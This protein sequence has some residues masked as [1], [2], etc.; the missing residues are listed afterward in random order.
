M[1]LESAPVR[2]APLVD[3]VKIQTPTMVELHGENFSSDLRVFFGEIPAVTRYG[4]GSLTEGR[5]LL[6]G[7]HLLDRHG[8]EA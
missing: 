1:E 3:T 6:V 7:A 8:A 5:L 2:P 4:R